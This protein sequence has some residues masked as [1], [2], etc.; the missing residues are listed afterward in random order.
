M[1]VIKSAQQLRDECAASPVAEHAVAIGWL[2]IHWTYLEVGLN[3]M[4][5]ALLGLERSD[6]DVRFAIT[7]NIDVREKMQIILAV[8]LKKRPF[9]QWYDSLKAILDKVDNELR[10]QR[11]RFMHDLWFG[12]DDRTVRKTHYRT[13]VKRPQAR[14]YFELTTYQE[15]MPSPNEVWDLSCRV[16]ATA[17]ALCRLAADLR[18]ASKRK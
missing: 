12:E 10:V 5:Y 17:H 1:T 4:I 3:E 8:G 11:N 15:S 16:Q 9:D 18:Q 7:S 13:S 14:Q 2:S 6:H